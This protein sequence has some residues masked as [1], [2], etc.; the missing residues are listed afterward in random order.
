M[1]KE[2]ANE[3]IARINKV[4]DYIDAHIGDDMTLMEL[5]DVAGFS[6]Y[7]FHRIFA[8]MTGETLFSFIQ[9]LRLER[10]AAL[11]C[12]PENGASVTAVA[13][14][15]GFSSPS[16]FSR[17]F[18][19]RFG[20]APSVFAHS[21]QCQEKSSLGKLLRNDGKEKDSALG[22]DEYT[23]MGNSSIRRFA[24][25][26]K[27]TI[28]KFEKTRVAYIRYVGPYAGDAQLFENLYGRLCAY[29]MPRGISMETSY[30]IYH[31]N[32]DITD[33]Q[34]L[35]LSVCVPIGDDV[36]V[37]GEICEMTIKGG[38]YAVGRFQLA[39]DEYGEAWNFMCGQWLPGSGYKPADAPSFERYTG[40]GEMDEGG[41]MS[42]DIC[43]PVEVI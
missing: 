14:R 1:N 2:Q 25:E 24:M 10:A 7:H 37:S 29:A 12:A 21:N 38:D 26:T 31:D 4:Y 8:A 30:I 23:P 42:V 43:I 22:Y 36:E 32:P 5:S 17:A 39:T 20:M 6:K 9:R 40:S 13:M 33:E 34:K 41:R 16:V 18:K 3:Y 11:L 15:L 19:K 28:E 35:R 27:V